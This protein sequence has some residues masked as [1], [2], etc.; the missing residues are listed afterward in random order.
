MWIAR[1]KIVIIRPEIMYLPSSFSMCDPDQVLKRLFGQI[2][3][4]L[5]NIIR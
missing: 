5:L 3:R 1:K 2:K 4:I